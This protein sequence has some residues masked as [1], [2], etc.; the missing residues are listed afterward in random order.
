MYIFEVLILL[1][2]FQAHQHA[3]NAPYSSHP[4][5]FSVS[6]NV[7][8][9]SHSSTLHGNDVNQIRAP[10]P[11]HSHHLTSSQLEIRSS[12]DRKSPA[13]ASSVKSYSEPAYPAYDSKA[14]LSNNR[15]LFVYN[16]SSPNLTFVYR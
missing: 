12:G 16:I 13:V 15:Y 6:R 4:R 10:P 8:K 2:V 5:D 14:A 3:P 7:H 9:N 11:A 1:W